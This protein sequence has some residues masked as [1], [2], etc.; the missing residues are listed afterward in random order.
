MAQ[1]EWNWPA[2]SISSTL[3]VGAA[4]AANQVIGNNSLASIDLKTPSLGQA[5]MAASVPI[6][7]ASNQTN[8][9]VTVSNFPAT[10]PISGTV[11]ATQSGTWN[12]GTLTS[13]TNALPAGSNAIGSV[14]VSNFPATQAVTQST[15]PWVVSGTVTSNRNPSGSY[16]EIVNL[17][18]TAQTF[19]APA[20]AVGFLME[21]LTD[22]SVNLRWKIGATATTTSGMRL[23]PGRDTGYF[24]CAGNISIIA[25]SGSNQVVTIQWTL[26]V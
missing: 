14:S 21:A 10:Q 7:I 11:S 24:P 2:I 26:S 9:P 8:V 5:L 20:N 16:S 3:P 6:T 12:I 22:N 17:T 13:I 25:E 15:S 4:T 23:E 18:T 19:T 1:Y